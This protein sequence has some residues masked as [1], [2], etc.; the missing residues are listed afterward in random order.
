MKQWETAID[1]FGLGLDRRQTAK[2]IEG[3][4]GVFPHV[5]SENELFFMLM[6]NKLGSY[7]S[8]ISH[9][10]PEL[11]AWVK[12]VKRDRGDWYMY[13]FE[14]H[15]DFAMYLEFLDKISDKVNSRI[16]EFF[17]KNCPEWVAKHA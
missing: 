13:T 10:H 4:G 15:D 5:K 12:I 11:L 14:E 7:L 16:L 2:E 9:H 6:K 8:Q 3:L 17:N 1:R